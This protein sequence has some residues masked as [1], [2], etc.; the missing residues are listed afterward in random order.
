MYAVK[1]GKKTERGFNMFLQIH[2]L[3][4]YPPSLLIRDQTG[5]VK[6]SIYGGI[7]RTRI[8][9]QG[10]K[11]RII[12]WMRA[13]GTFQDGVR[14]RVIF[15]RIA[16]ELVDEGKNYEGVAYV[17]QKMAKLIFGGKGDK[18]ILD[19]NLRTSNSI[20]LGR[21]EVEYI[22]DIAR[23]TLD[24]VEEKGLDFQKEDDQKEID[25]TIVTCMSRHDESLRNVFRKDL[26]AGFESALFG[27]FVTSDILSRVDAPVHVAHPL[28]VHAHLAETDFYSTLDDLVRQASYTDTMDLNAGLFYGYVV[29]HIPLL[30]ANLSGINPVSWRHATEAHD[31]TTRL[32]RT[33]IRALTTI[34]PG[35]KL[36]AT[37]PYARAGY[38]LL[39]AGTDFPRSL[40]EAYLNPIEIGPDMMLRSIDALEMQLRAVDRIYGV[41]DVKRY[42]STIYASSL[43]G[44]TGSLD[45]IIDRMFLDIFGGGTE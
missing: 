25:A 37:A 26:P 7:E 8:S 30:V 11:R 31:T 14:S 24:E 42:V 17:L 13:Q 3:T 12:D 10:W 29:V 27:R 2:T 16:Q 34:T 1:F 9:S 21:T 43:E 18:D 33:L 36:G 5:S 23:D 28:T 44:E 38:I 45:E 40:M 35:A 41:G 6:T 4:H 32:L 15:E 20:S 22:R 39:E 19:V